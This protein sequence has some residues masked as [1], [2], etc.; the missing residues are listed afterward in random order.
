MLQESAERFLQEH[1]STAVA[2]AA[3]ALPAGLDLPLWQ[4]ITSTLGWQ[5]VVVPEEQDGLGL[6]VVE[7]GSGCPRGT[8][9]RCSPCST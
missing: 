7:L 4:Q 5:A 2:R 6:G 1:S 3:A 8:S 9:S